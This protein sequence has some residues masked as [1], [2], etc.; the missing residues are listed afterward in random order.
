MDIHVLIEFYIAE[1]TANKYSTLLIESYNDLIIR[2]GGRLSKDKRE[3]IKNRIDKLNNSIN[4]KIETIHSYESMIINLI[5]Q[6]SDYE[7]DELSEYLREKLDIIKDNIVITNLE[8]ETI[9]YTNDLEEYTKL[10]SNILLKPTI[11][12]EEY[13]D[14]KILLI[15]LNLRRESYE[16]ITNILERSKKPS[17]KP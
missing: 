7:K 14:K 3:I 16:F 12:P 5:E 15:N 1:R 6:L 13:K 11:I 8:L 2:T 10:F 4:K 17:M 9:E